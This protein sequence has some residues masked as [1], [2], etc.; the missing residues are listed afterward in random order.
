MKINTHYANISPNYTYNEKGVRKNL[1]RIS[2]HTFYVQTS[3]MAWWSEFLT[4]SH[5]VPGSILG[6]AVG[7]FPYKGRSP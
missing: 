3:L 6:S 7:I 1:K 5:E 2:K 4:T